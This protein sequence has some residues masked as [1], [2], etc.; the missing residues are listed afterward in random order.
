MADYLD[1]KVDEILKYL[2]CNTI[3]KGLKKLEELEKKY[4][5]QNGLIIDELKFKSPK[6][7]QK[8]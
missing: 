1:G 7:G 3:E 4:S 2:N 8:W 6:R 5:R